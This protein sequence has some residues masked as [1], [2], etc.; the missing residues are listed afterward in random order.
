LESGVGKHAL[1]DL[2]AL[3]GSKSS[4]PRSRQVKSR[5]NPSNNL[6]RNGLVHEMLCSMPFDDSS[7]DD[8]EASNG[9]DETQTNVTGIEMNDGSSVVSGAGKRAL[10][11]LLDCAANGIHSRAVNSRRSK[12]ARRIADYEDDSEHDTVSSGVGENALQTLLSKARDELSQS[13]TR[14]KSS[15]SKRKATAQSRRP[16]NTGGSSPRHCTNYETCLGSDAYIGDG[17][18]SIDDDTVT[19]GAG[20][21]ALQS[22]L[23]KARPPRMKNKSSTPKRKA[24]A[25]S[26]RATNPGGSLAPYRAKDETHENS[27]SYIGEGCESIH[28]DTVTSDAGKKALETLLLQVSGSSSSSAM[29]TTVPLKSNIQKRRKCKITEEDYGTT[30]IHL[31]VKHFTGHRIVTSGEKK[32]TMEGPREVAVTVHKHQTPL[33][34]NDFD[35]QESGDDFNQS[36][37]ASSQ[38]KSCRQIDITFHPADSRSVDPSIA[39]SK[40]ANE[41]DSS[42]ATDTGANALS[43]LLKKVINIETRH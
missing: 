16:T 2:L 5:Q 17:F 28:D 31:N 41:D 13:R 27:D 42:L 35:L 18:E 9:G 22:L 8:D 24:T 10:Q 12:K 23:S 39:T 40:M 38:K 33:K 21:K 1:D 3:A 43:A 36:P 26:R 29:K 6:R 14:N 7:F 37:V 20:R 4:L 25:R 32:K 11:S 30:N 19:S 15:T 34:T